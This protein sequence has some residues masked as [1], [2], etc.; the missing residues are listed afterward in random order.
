MT[1]PHLQSMEKQINKNG[2]ANAPFHY[3]KGPNPENNPMTFKDTQ[4][5]KPK[6][7]SPI[8]HMAF[9]IHI[10]YGGSALDNWLEAEQ[11]VMSNGYSPKNW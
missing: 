9:Q 6:D 5:I 4:R 2:Y 10:A 11:I 7:D 8:R 1:K 3:L